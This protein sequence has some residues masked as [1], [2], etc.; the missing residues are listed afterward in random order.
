MEDV[1]LRRQAGEGAPLGQLPPGEATGALQ[2]DV[3]LRVELVAL[4]DDELRVDALAPQR[5]DVLP[6]N[7]SRV[8]GT[9]GYA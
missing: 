2:G 6:R 5:L 8:D 7:T 4:E 9:V 1:G 3:R